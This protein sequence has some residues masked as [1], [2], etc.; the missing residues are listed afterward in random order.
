M[1]VCDPVG[2]M[3]SLWTG[4]L[5]PQIFADAPP[6]E[7]DQDYA[8]ALVAMIERHADEIAAVIV[9][10]V[11]QGAG[12]MRFHH[13]AYLRVLRDA[14]AAYGIFLIFDEIATGFGRTGTFFAAE[15]AGVSPDIMCVGKALTGG[16]LTLAATLCTPAVAEAI[17]AGEG[18]GLAHGPTFMGNP[19]ACAVANASLG[20]LRG[21]DW[22]DRVQVIEIGLRDGL[23]P[24]RGASG[25]R[26]VRVLGA[27]GVV[28]LDHP[29]DMAKATAAAAGAGVWLRPFRDLIY[30]MPPYVADAADVARITT[31]IAAAVAAS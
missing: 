22:A 8:D 6:A 26:D 18:G 30:T 17:S 23:A 13:P 21:G 20:L 4:V 28:Q 5:P 16:Y 24:L 27:I 9:E 14:T 15:Q 3:H 1:S 7:F 2:G 25:V 10:P 12:G 19:L 29:V 31:A 11:V